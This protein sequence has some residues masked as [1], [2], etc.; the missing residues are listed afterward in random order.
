M[1]NGL[2]KSF[3]LTLYSCKRKM[4]FYYSEYQLFHCLN[5]DY[6]LSD[7]KNFLAYMIFKQIY[8]LN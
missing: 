2:I 3:S 1:I 6:G 4:K 8:I 7:E 5:L